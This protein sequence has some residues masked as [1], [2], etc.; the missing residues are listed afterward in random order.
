MDTQWNKDRKKLVQELNVNLKD[1]VKKRKEE[2][3]QTFELWTLQQC[4]EWLQIENEDMKLD[5]DIIQKFEMISLNGSTLKEVNNS[6]LKV[7]G[8]DDRDQRKMVIKSIERL[9]DG[10]GGRK[11]QKAQLCCICMMN[12][13][14][15][16][17]VPCGHMCYCDQCGKKSFRHT[18]NC[19]ICRK[20]IVT[21][22]V[23]FK[24]GLED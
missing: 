22:V 12:E 19:P 18:N 9:F 16:C 8:M 21:L 2:L 23:T 15:T 11:Y 6:L 17:L 14:N 24:A 1:L 4:V 13:V 7:I 10:Y 20:S 5:D 3:Y